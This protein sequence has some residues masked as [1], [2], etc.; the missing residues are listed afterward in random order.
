MLKICCILYFLLISPVNKIFIDNAAIWKQLDE[1]TWRKENNWAGEGYTFYQTNDGVKRCVSQVYGSGVYVVSELT[2][3]KVEIKNDTIQLLIN[4]A[5]SPA[6]RDYQV[7]EKLILND[8]KMKT[9]DNKFSFVLFS[10][11]PVIYDIQNP[12]SGKMIPIEE[13]KKHQ[14]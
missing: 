14:E 12:S 5:A 3:Y 1:T 2:F 11:T 4:I 13:L 6:H 7:M 8:G 9:S 10:K